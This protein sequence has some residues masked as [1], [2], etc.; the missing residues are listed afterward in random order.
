[1]IVFRRS[2]LSCV[3][4]P[5][6]PFATFFGGRLSELRPESGRPCVKNKA[7]HMN[8]L[9]KSS[10]ESKVFPSVGKAFSRTAFE[11]LNVRGRVLVIDDSSR[12]KTSIHRWENQPWF[13]DIAWH[14]GVRAIVNL[15]MSEHAS[16]L[17]IED[18]TSRCRS[19]SDG[20]AA[21]IR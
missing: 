7:I 10:H 3:I 15:E 14:C 6:R 19:P 2:E 17:L 9:L 13:C 11:P 1:M 18:K 12:S 5:F 16:C 21:S 8:G 4:L 20:S